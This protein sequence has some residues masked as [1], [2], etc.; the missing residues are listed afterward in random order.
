MEKEKGRSIDT[1]EKEGTGKR[2]RR[3]G[4]R[5]FSGTVQR[6]GV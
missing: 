2:K 5:K 6:V 3:R 4:E 1:K